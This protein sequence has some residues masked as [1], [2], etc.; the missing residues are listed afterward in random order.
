M[1]PQADRRVSAAIATVVLNMTV[2]FAKELRC[3]DALV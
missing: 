1:L 3:V 2:S